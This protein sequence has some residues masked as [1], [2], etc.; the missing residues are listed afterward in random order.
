MSERERNEYITCPALRAY[1][2]RIGAE[3]R[4]FRR[5][6]I[7]REVGDGYHRDHYVINITEDGTVEV[8]AT[9]GSEV[10]ED[11]KPTEAEQSDIKAGIS[12]IPN[13]IAARN[14]EGLV[15]MLG[16]DAVLIEFRAP[17]NDRGDNVLFVQQRLVLKNGNKIYL[18]WSFWS[19][20]EWRRM[21]PLGPLPLYGLDRLHERSLVML[22]EGAKGARDVQA[23][24]DSGG[25][26]PWLAELK[27]ATHIGWAGGVERAGDVDFLPLKKLNPRIRLIV[28]ADYDQ[29]G[30]DAVA[31]ISR[32]LGR[33]MQMLVFDE[34]FP[35]N[36]DL[37]DRWPNNPRW[38]SARQRY[39]GPTMDDCLVPATMATK[40]FTV[41][42]GNK[43]HA[44]RKQ[45]AAEW[46]WVSDPAVFIYKRQN[47]RML[48]DI[49]FNRTVRPFSHV[50]NTARL[51]LRFESS[52]ADGVQYAPDEK[53][54]LINKDGRRL[55]N[56]Y[57][58]PTIKAIEGSVEPFLKFMEHLIPI[59][60]DR[61]EMLR[62][63]ATLIARPDIRM[64]YGVL[65]I[66]EVQGVGKGTLGEKILAP[67][68]G[69]NNVSFPS[70]QE[71]CESSFNSWLVC[72]RLA[73]VHEIYSGDSRKA[74][75]KLKS[76]ITDRKITAS[77]KYIA[78]Y[79][80]D[81][82][83]HAFACSNSLA[84]LKLDLYDRRW[85]VPAV[86]NELRTTE[87]WRELNEWLEEDGL[88]NILAWAIAYVKEHKPVRSGEH[89]PMTQM[90]R[91]VIDANRTRGAQL[92]YDL[93]T[94]MMEKSPSERFVLLMSDV[95]KW[96]AGR[97]G[98]S[99]DDPYLEKLL[100]LRKTML[101]VGVFEP[102]TKDHRLKVTTARGTSDMEYVVAN[103][104]IGASWPDIAADLKRPDD[105]WAISR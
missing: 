98:K 84:A 103:F 57:R 19:D 100:T 40:E 46:Y 62:W 52:H 29:G 13:S 88:G 35:V 63:I 64:T 96:V 36:F 90:K 6:V 38:W 3:Q 59:K 70:E 25:P 11:I 91:E 45:F 8:R 75:N 10:P 55:V 54:G 92:V 23:L 14:T 51:L 61:D 7:Q 34:R 82:W 69:L 49:A 12:A 66:S 86:T 1:I 26:H 97:L 28:V 44:I 85:L 39:I 31:K 73:V 56:T 93:A 42:S 72:K 58:P 80:I 95:R 87:E 89:A 78:N 2:A 5:F 18:P 65:L 67:L 102:T 104:P 79:L 27:M 83:I 81:N 71:I 20:S 77:L 37:A 53:P 105:V 9:D 30:I 43:A 22:H 15:E 32:I 101:A 41:E 50:D 99:I 33:S 4:N 47:D 16:R 68:V 48:S 24:V 17:E 76:A 60:E 74:Y 21:E 94:E